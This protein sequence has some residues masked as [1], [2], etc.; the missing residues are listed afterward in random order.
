MR[1]TGWM[2]L[3]ALFSGIS[4]AMAPDVYVLRIRDAAPVTLCASDVLA[5]SPSPEDVL[6]VF[7]GGEKVEWHILTRG[8][9]SAIVANV[10]LALKEKPEL[11]KDPAWREGWVT[12]EHWQR[13]ATCGLPGTGVKSAS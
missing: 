10:K 5:T 3:A 13:A 7:P 4:I 12:V 9:A 11:L 1:T 6:A 2:L 8:N